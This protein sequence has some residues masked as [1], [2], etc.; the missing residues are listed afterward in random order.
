MNLPEAS[1]LH[2]AWRMRFRFAQKALA[3]L[4]LDGEV[5]IKTLVFLDR[6]RSSELA[7]I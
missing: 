4:G 2:T 7:K 3:F 6:S 1:T 5:N